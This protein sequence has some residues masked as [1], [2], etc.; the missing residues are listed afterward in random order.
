MKYFAFILLTMMSLHSFGMNDLER[1]ALFYSN[2]YSYGTFLPD[3]ES[4]M[5]LIRLEYE[6]KKSELKMSFEA[7]FRASQIEQIRHAITINKEYIRSFAA[8]KSM[9]EAKLKSFSILVGYAKNLFKGSVSR[10]LILNEIAIYAEEDES[11]KKDW[12][13]ILIESGALE[14]ESSI[15]EKNELIF[16]TAL[17]I[18]AQLEVLQSSIQIQIDDLEEENQQLDEQLRTIQ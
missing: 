9:A 15:S 16:S 14:V 5:T 18:Q 4:R 7:N 8:E 3:M 12:N 10:E 17:E 6:K 13:Q 11:F 1:G 2:L